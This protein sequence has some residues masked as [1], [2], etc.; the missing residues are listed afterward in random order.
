MNDVLVP[1]KCR[2]CG[3]TDTT[4][5]EMP[6]AAPGLRENSLWDAQGFFACWWVDE[7][8]TLCSNPRCVGVIP[9]HE[10]LGEIHREV[11]D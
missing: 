2:V 6:E 8:R 3:C 5:C 11:I 9:L 4:P 1:G 7:S 10:L